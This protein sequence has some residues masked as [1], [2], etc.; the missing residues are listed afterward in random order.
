MKQVF[1][2]LVILI[3]V[4]VVACSAQSNDGTYIDLT[5]EEFKAKMTEQ[6]VVVLDVRTPAEIAKG[7]IRGAVE[8][9]YKAA[10]FQE[11]IAALDK[12]KTYLIYCASGGRS[13]RTCKSMHGQ[14]FP[15][16]Y[17]LSGGYKAW[18]SAK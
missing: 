8:I 10:D 17:N 18:K 1:F 7:K 14:D 9:D 3:A 16:L 5:G 15:N 2:F 6:D 12:E 11:K 13:S 4:T